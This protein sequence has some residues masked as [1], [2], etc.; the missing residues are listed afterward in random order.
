M[1]SLDLIL[2]QVKIAHSKRQ[3]TLA[4]EKE[5]LK[6]GSADAERRWLCIEIEMDKA[7]HVNKKS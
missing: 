6:V 4:S 2:V 3:V 1:L 7:T 5:R